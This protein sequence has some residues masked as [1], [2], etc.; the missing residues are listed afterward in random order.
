MIDP[1][2]AAKRCRCQDL[3]GRI[4]IYLNPFCRHAANHRPW[5]FYGYPHNSIITSAA[6]YHR[7]WMADEY[8][9]EPQ[10]RPGYRP[11]GHVP[12]VHGT[13]A[14]YVPAARP[15]LVKRETWTEPV[16][17][18]PIVPATPGKIDVVKQLPRAFRGGM[19][20]LKIKS[21]TLVFPGH[22]PAIPAGA[23]ATIKKLSL[24]PNVDIVSTYARG[25]EMSADGSAARAAIWEK[26][27]PDETDP[28]SRVKIGEREPEPVDSILV[29][30]TWRYLGKPVRIDVG[31][32]VAGSPE[33]FWNWT[34]EQGVRLLGWTEWSAQ[35]GS[36][37]GNVYRD[38]HGRNVPFAWYHAEHP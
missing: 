7:A 27:V 24:R 3:N 15:P 4:W 1:D 34:L 33:S 12:V 31:V 38:A 9:G 37:E 36:D 5:E 30:G 14:D 16:M 32:W 26:R 18:A 17:P 6:E 21:A 35:I 29:R 20:A 8:G 19:T 11:T 2:E 22:D 28:R 23:V 10:F 13:P 25:F